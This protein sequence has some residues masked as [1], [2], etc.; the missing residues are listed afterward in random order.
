MN[1]LFLNIVRDV[2]LRVSSFSLLNVFF[3]FSF[4]FHL[5]ILHFRSSSINFLFLYIV[6][7]VIFLVSSFFLLQFL[8]FSHSNVSLRFYMEFHLEIL[9]F[10]SDSMNFLL[11]EIFFF[12]FLYFLFFNSLKF[13]LWNVEGEGEKVKWKMKRISCQS[14]HCLTL[15]LKRWW[16]WYSF[17]FHLRVLTLSFTFT[18]TLNPTSVNLFFAIGLVT[19]TCFLLCERF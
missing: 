1:I 10:Q 8:E 12:Q 15:T 19:T 11:Y 6:R 18:L 2:I 17:H 3:Q 14:P 4:D 7:H 16:T 13:F 5:E 9:H